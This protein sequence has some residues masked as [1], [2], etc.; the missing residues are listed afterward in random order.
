MVKLCNEFFLITCCVGWTASLNSLD[1]VVNGQNYSGD[2]FCIGD[3]IEFICTLQG[4]LHAW[5]W[6]IPDYLETNNAAQLDPDSLPIN[7]GPEGMFRFE[8][9]EFM[10]GQLI[11]SFSVTVFSL[12]D[13]TTIDCVELYSSNQPLRIILHIFGTTSRKLA[14]CYNI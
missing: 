3:K 9:K 1:V 7:L 13:G 6:D 14:F 12:L 11:T 5:I 2:I 4:E 8:V 10:P